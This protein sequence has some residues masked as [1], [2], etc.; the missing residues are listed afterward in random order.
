MAQESRARKFE[1]AG[2]YMALHDLLRE[3]HRVCKYMDQG[4]RYTLGGEMRQN[5]GQAARYIFRA[6]YCQKEEVKERKE[7]LKRGISFLVM[8]LM[9]KRVAET[10]QQFNR[11]RKPDVS[12]SAPQYELLIV[13]CIEQSER[14]LNF[15]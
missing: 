15:S 5:A 7:F 12:A 8:L 13:D 9:S 2:L 3:T 11:G 10:L 1:K 14:F 6:Y 4:Y